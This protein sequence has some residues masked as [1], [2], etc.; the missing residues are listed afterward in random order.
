M[1]VRVHFFSEQT[2]QVQL[3]N[4]ARQ[5]MTLEEHHVSHMNNV[6]EDVRLLSGIY[7]LFLL[8]L[9]NSSIFACWA[10]SSLA[11]A[12]MITTH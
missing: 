4:D 7:A 1:I 2:C 6:N 3:H 5:H 11:L 12:C 10:F 8:H 9:A